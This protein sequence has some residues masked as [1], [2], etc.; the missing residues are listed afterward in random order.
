VPPVIVELGKSATSI[1]SDFLPFSA[2]LSMMQILNMYSEQEKTWIR[3][4]AGLI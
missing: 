1:L 3:N 2:L 4:S